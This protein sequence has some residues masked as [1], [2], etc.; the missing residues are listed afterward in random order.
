MKAM[1]AGERPAPPGLRGP[2]L[3]QEGQMIK[4]LAKIRQFVFG[5]AAILPHSFYVHDGVDGFQLIAVEST[6]W[7]IV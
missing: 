5:R 7:R 6:A 1:G 2:R 4:F 3:L